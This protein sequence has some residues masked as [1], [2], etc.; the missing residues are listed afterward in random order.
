[1]VALVYVLFIS[2]TFS[3]IAYTFITTSIKFNFPKINKESMD[4]NSFS[5]FTSLYPREEEKTN[6]PPVLI[7]LISTVTGS[8]KLALIEV[9][10]NS[11]IVRIGSQVGDMKVVDI[12]RNYIILSKNEEKIV[13]S[14]DYKQE[15]SSKALSTSTETP[16]KSLQATIPRGELE[17]ITSDPG[18]MFRQIRLV[19]FVEGG[20]TKGFLFEWVES[21]SI[22]DRAGIKQGDVLLSINNQEIKSGE[23]AFRILQ[24]LR[25]ESSIKLSI[26]RGGEIMEILLRIE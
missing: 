7:N 13:V 25:N 11:Q 21:G 1:M 12:Q 2:F 24:I 20:R 9:N 6:S 15:A 22:F 4:I 18:L 16:S 14:F 8:V 23:D 19:P 26:E 5:K 10:G 17:R 3:V